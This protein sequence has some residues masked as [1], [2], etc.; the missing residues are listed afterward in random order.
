MKIILFFKTILLFSFFLLKVVIGDYFSPKIELFDSLLSNNK[1]NTFKT[2][3]PSGITF[4]KY[5]SLNG[6]VASCSND[7]T[8]NVWNPNTGESIRIYT[9]HKNTVEFLDQIDECTLV[10]G[11][12]DNAIHIWNLNTGLTEN[13]ID[14]GASVGSIKFLPN[15]LIACGLGGNINIYQYSTGNL[16]K[17]LIGH[18]DSVSSIEI[19][20]ERFIASVSADTSVIIWDLTSYSIRHNLLRHE[21]GVICVKRLSATLMASGDDNGSIIIWNWLNG[22]LVHKLYGHQGSVSSLELYDDQTLISSSWD[23]TVDLWNITNGQLI[24][25]INTGFYIKALV[26]LNSGKRGFFFHLLTGRPRF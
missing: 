1:I 17:T 7:N 2:F 25:S 18:S 8:V 26:M 13:I 4:L 9:K 16:T 3:H 20:N 23:K 6:Y 22:S 11:S 24:K 19:L 21:S 10:S 12:R 5:L 14:V 15:G